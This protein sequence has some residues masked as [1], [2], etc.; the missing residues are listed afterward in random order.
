MR[1]LQL[2]R[3]YSNSNGR[4][5]DN[6]SIY[7][8]NQWPNT[9]IVNDTLSRETATHTRQRCE[10]LTWLAVINH[11]YWL[12]S[13]KNCL[14]SQKGTTRSCTILRAESRIRKAFKLWVCG[15]GR[16]D[17]WKNQRWKKICASFPSK[18]LCC[19]LI[20]CTDLWIFSCFSCKTELKSLDINQSS[21][22]CPNLK[23]QFSRKQA[24][25][26]RFQSVKTSVLGLFSRKLGLKIQSKITKRQCT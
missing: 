21:D 5:I 4:N 24:Q 13:S 14:S 11:R 12:S 6:I 25:N 7:I 2:F 8:I 22:K 1:F 16:P 9:T 17:L 15:L 18:A 3:S 26:A 20:L 23:T 10:E 19:A